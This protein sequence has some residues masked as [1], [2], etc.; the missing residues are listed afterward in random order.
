ML[1]DSNAAREAYTRIVFVVYHH[2]CLTYVA[3]AIS[4]FPRAHVSETRR[5]SRAT[6]STSS[7]ELTNAVATLG[8][9]M[10]VSRAARCVAA[11]SA[12]AFAKF[13]C[14]L[15]FVFRTPFVRRLSCG[16]LLSTAFDYIETSVKRVK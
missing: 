6:F 3:H 1:R 9:R 2:T 15:L 16:L 8:R 11:V 14:D 4:T 5:D 13:D 10:Y 12:S 7:A